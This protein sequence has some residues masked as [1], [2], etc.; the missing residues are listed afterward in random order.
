MQ[1]FKKYCRKPNFSLQQFANRMTEMENCETNLPCGQTKFLFTQ[2]FAVYNG[3]PLPPNV[4]PNSCQY[5]KLILT[6]FC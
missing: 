3:G 2:V 5:R 1:V 6:E 4:N